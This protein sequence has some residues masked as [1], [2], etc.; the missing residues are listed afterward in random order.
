LHHGAAERALWGAL[1]PAQPRSLLAPDRLAAPLRSPGRPHVPNPP[2]ELVGRGRGVTVLPAS[3]ARGEG[4]HMK[5]G[6]GVEGSESVV[7]ART[8]E[9]GATYPSTGLRPVP[10]RPLRAGR[11][12]SP[13]PPPRP[14]A[15]SPCPPR[16]S[17][18]APRP[19]A[20]PAPS[21]ATSP[22]RRAVSRPSFRRQASRI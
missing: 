4:D 3:E 17:P 12:S 22:A 1:H 16:S 14:A 2:L 21:P 5:C 20:P 6:G 11:T 15:P 8:S 19:K 13:R 9:V 18:P 7:L 10:L